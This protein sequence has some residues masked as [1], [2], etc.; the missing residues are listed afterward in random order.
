MSQFTTTFESTQHGGVES[1]QHARGPVLTC[2]ALPCVSQD[3]ACVCTGMTLRLSGFTETCASILNDVVISITIG[4]GCSWSGSLVSGNITLTSCSISS[5]G[6][7]GAN[8]CVIITGTVDPGG[9]CDD[10]FTLTA[11]VCNSQTPSCPI[12]VYPALAFMTSKPDDFGGC[13]RIT[14]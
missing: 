9:A 1:T 2:E 5:C 3:F 10:T 11:E 12:G 8:W 7:G 14:A 6:A 13:L 4:L